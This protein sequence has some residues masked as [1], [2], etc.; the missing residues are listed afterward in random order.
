M[1]KRLT[2]IGTGPAGYIAAIRAAQLGFDVTAIEKWDRLGGTCLNVGCIPSKSLLND[3]FYFKKGVPNDLS[4]MMTKKE[5]VVKGLTE[6][7]AGLFKKNGVKLLKGEASFV[8]DKK[9]KVGSH[10]LESDFILIASGSVPSQIPFLPFDEVKVVSSTG[11]LDFKDPPK[12]LAVIGGGVIGVELA[13]VW[14]RLG[15]KVTV[16]E[17]LPEIVSTMDSSISRAL[18][19]ILKKQGIEFLLNTKLLGADL[20]GEGV[21]LQV[22]GSTIKAD[23]VLVATGR[24]PFTH[25][26]NLE[27]AGIKLDAR[28]FIPINGSFQTSCPSIYAVGDVVEGPMLAH[29]AMEEGAAAVEAMAGISAH[30]SYISIPNVV[31]THPEA[32][33]VGLTE[34]EAKATG[35]ELLVGTCSMKAIARARCNGDTDG[36]VKIIGDKKTGRLLG[37]HIIAEAASEMIGE[38]VI[39]L[40]HKSTVEELANASHAHPA[41]S[42]AIK[43]GALAAL[44]RPLSF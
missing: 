3:T 40:N 25:N 32:A 6:G 36:F 37:M 12:H 28:G 26:L 27:A 22:E 44:G 9:V 20:S 11:A 4:A 8:S 42:E 15:S 10:E 35:R 31:Y 17:M 16:I 23:K 34:T 19:S 5:D 43:E 38:G 2:V 33:S 7:V 1:A 30:M 24:K 41:L 21:E 14:S 18:L 13:S 39:A 29:K